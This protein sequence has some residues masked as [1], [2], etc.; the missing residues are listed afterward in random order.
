M[1]REIAI[2]IYLAIFRVLF[3]MFNLI[4]TSNKTTFVV[5][6]GGNV[7]ATLHSHERLV[8]NQQVV[9]LKSPGCNTNFSTNNRIILDFRPKNIIQFLQS[10]Y[11]LA[12]SNHIIID[13]Y[14]AFLSATNF[15]SD[16]KC[17]QLW[18]A[19][20][21]IKKFGLEDLTNEQRTPRALKRFKSVY[22]R[23]DFV[24]VGSDQMAEIFK[25]SF[26]LT[27][28]KFI[29][30]GI[31]RTDFFFN[32]DKIRLAKEEIED[33]F[34][35][36]INKKGLLYAP[37]YRDHDLQSTTLHLDLDKMYDHFKYEYVLFLRLHPA[38]A[39]D[40]VNKYPGFIFNVSDY[41]SINNLLI[42]ADILITD[43][44][45]IPFEFS[46]LNK[47]TV[48][49]MYDYKEYSRNR[50]ISIED[51]ATLP[52]PITSSTEEL[53]QIIDTKEF[54]TE[55]IKPFADEWNKYSRGNSSDNLIY[56][57]F[58]DRVID[59]EIQEGKYA[60]TS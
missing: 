23:F 5:S 16:V 22:N 41:H 40:Y 2:T 6:F 60:S 45:S 47:P 19:A 28:D 25:R 29:Y 53:I 43:Y 8:V 58:K 31:P 17:T 38:V 52:G 49:Y 39:S 24:T 18:H 15:K 26:G 55:L 48:F 14:Y 4:E 50:G 13:N 7:K 44:S 51:I 21:A 12:T 34:P 59:S 33:D 27:N 10:I 35:S 1:A 57:L 9:I 32:K 37:T 36:I 42:G 54:K 20:G 3:Q 56:T 11:H 46:L 30:S